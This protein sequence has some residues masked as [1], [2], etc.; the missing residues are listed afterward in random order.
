MQLKKISD[1]REDKIKYYEHTEEERG[2]FK[3]REL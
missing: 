3:G 2:F 1:L